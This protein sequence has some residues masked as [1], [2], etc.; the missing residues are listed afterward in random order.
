MDKIE[1]QAFVAGVGVCG[2]RSYT[3][4]GVLLSMDIKMTFR[5]FWKFGRFQPS[6]ARAIYIDD[7]ARTRVGMGLRGYTS[8]TD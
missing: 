2:K 4:I 3:D 6:T 7:T 5:S 8:C 1:R